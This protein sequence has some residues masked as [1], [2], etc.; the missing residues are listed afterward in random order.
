[1]GGGNL[2]TV[3]GRRR[4]A[5][6]RVLVG[7]GLTVS[8]G[9]L[10]ACSEQSDTVPNE[11]S[12]AADENLSETTSIGVIGRGFL[13]INAKVPVGSSVTWT[14]QDAEAHTVV[15]GYRGV[16]RGGGREDLGV[17]DGLRG[18]FDQALNK[19]GDIFEFTVEKAGTYDYHCKIHVGMDGR[20]LVE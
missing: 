1:M 2:T 14:N 9:W 6:T 13:P 5:A 18:A 16:Q 19:K 3:A 4:T 11:F 15:G 7:I 17:S 20:L 12:K 10:A 8:V